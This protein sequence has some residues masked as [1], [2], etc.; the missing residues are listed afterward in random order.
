LF[1]H[2]PTIW[3]LLWALL[4]SCKQ[5]IVTVALS[6]H[7]WQFSFW[8]QSSKLEPR[9]TIQ[10]TFGTSR[11]ICFERIQPNNHRITTVLQIW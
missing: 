7:P 1:H 3:K 4:S 9:A 5:G 10:S 2:I 6:S 8:V 11:S